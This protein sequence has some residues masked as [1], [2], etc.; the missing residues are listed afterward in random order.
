MLGDISGLGKIYI[1]CG[2]TDCACI[3]LN[4]ALVHLIGFPKGSLI[5]ASPVPLRGNEMTLG[6]DKI[7]VI[8]DIS[9][10]AC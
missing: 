6:W 4:K 8:S 7:P 2:Y 10:Y 1:V 9:F 5:S 3:Y